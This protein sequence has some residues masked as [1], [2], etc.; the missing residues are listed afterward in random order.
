[1]DD[2][3]KLVARAAQGGDR[4]AF[5]VLYERI[6]PALYAWA[7]FK[8]PPTLRA[9]VSAEDL[10]Q[11]VWFR[12]FRK[13]AD[14]DAARSFRAWLFGFANRVL[15]EMLKSRALGEVSSGYADGG[16][17]LGA[18]PADV[19]AI[20]RRAARS[21]GARALL[22]CFEGLEAE[23]EQ[24]LALRGL[25]GLPYEEVGRQLDVSAAVARKRWERLRK[26]LHEQGAPEDLLER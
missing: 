24:M 7:R 8:V 17:D 22:S 11:E 9:V 21:E 3:T 1:M 13:L 10:L 19:T 23:E 25:E 15:F 18:V 5:N 20:S 16:F 4:D 14:Y 26:K 6:A 12:S 2:E